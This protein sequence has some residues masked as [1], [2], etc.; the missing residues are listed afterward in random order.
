MLS[1]RVKFI[2][3]SKDEISFLRKKI[4]REISKLNEIIEKEVKKRLR[5]FSPG[6]QV[7]VS[8]INEEHFEE[9]K[10]RN[11]PVCVSIESLNGKFVHE[12]GFWVDEIYT[13]GN[14]DGFIKVE[15]IVTVQQLNDLCFE[16]SED[17]GV[18]IKYLKHQGKIIY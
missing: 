5:K 15:N 7:R 1:K 8:K 3:D 16:L 14:F 2:R 18:E 11:I 12:N 17:L 10:K 6:I 13:N 4:K 9:N